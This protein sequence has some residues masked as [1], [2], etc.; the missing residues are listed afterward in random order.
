MHTRSHK[1]V[2]QE[3]RPPLAPGNRLARRLSKGW[4]HKMLFVPLSFAQ[5]DRQGPDLPV[6]AFLVWVAPFVFLV[7]PMLAVGLIRVVAPWTRQDCDRYL[8]RLASLLEGSLTTSVAYR[9]AW[10][11]NRRPPRSPERPR[12][13]TRPLE[14]ARPG[15]T[16]GRVRSRGRGVDRAEQNRSSS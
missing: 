6:S 15:Q 8:K 10:P 16:T 4:Q 7:P 3:M 11:A 1:T 2:V 13:R 14:A 9:T 12:N 5:N